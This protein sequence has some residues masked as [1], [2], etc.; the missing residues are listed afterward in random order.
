MTRRALASIVGVAV[1][2]LAL[3][4]I[5]LALAVRTM[6]QNNELLELERVATRQSARITVANVA[7]TRVVDFVTVEPEMHVGVYDTAAHR[8]GGT[9]PERLDRASRRAAR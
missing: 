9:G 1:V 8:V 7:R 2:A 5:P 4:G 6:T 3:F